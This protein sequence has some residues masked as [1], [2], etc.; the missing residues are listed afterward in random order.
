MKILIW[1]GC[2][3]LNYIIQLICKAIISC[4]PTTDDSSMI[5]VAT[6]NGLLAAASIGF[7][8]WLASKLCK[9][10]DWHRVTQ[11]AMEAGMTVTE[12]GKQ[13]LSEEFLTKVDKL[14]NSVPIEQAKPQ[15]K[16]CVKKGKI[17]KDQYIILLEEYTKVK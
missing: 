16:A 6:L 13:G 2:M 5:L 15:L 9:K 7:C 10:F 12:Y 4:I 11:K 17:T 1:I 14:F 3:T 8:V